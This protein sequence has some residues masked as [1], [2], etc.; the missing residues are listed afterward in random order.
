MK[1]LVRL[2][3]GLERMNRTYNKII[4]CR[5]YPHFIGVGLVILIN[6]FFQ[7]ILYTQRT[8][9]IF[10]ISFDLV[11]ACVIGLSLITFLDL[12]ATILV[13]LLVSH[14]INWVFNSN[15]IALFKNFKMI[16]TTKNE[17]EQYIDTLKECITKKHFI[18]SALLIGSLV[19]SH[20][21]EYSDVDIRLVRRKGFLNGI[22]ACGYLMAIRSRALYDLFPLDI[23]VLDRISGNDYGEMPQMLKQ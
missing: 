22:L 13:S 12:I 21:S 23:Y 3:L 9:K 18:Q 17:R 16:K 11:L 20:D 19:D 10:K 7:S 5:F 15:I 4:E 2:F 1:F 14:S 8:E 6:W